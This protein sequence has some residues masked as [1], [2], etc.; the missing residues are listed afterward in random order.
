MSR[1]VTHEDPFCYFLRI[2]SWELESWSLAQ[3]EVVDSPALE[4]GNS[5]MMKPQLN[6]GMREN[7]DWIDLHGKPGSV[8]QTRQRVRVVLCLEAYT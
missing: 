2:R 1:L 5:R 6:S 7:N 3:E 4:N 8:E